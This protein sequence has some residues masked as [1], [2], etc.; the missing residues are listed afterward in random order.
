ML[1]R[2]EEERERAGR[3][4]AEAQRLRAQLEDLR[5]ERAR[6]QRRLERLDPCARLLERALEQLPEV[7]CVRLGLWGDFGH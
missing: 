3:R 5:R 2:A 4:E 7:S 1:Q 6:L